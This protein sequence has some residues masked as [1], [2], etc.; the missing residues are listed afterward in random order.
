MVNVY[1]LKNLLSY[2]FDAVMIDVYYLLKVVRIYIKIK[3]QVSYNTVAQKEAVLTTEL[4]IMTNSNLI[5][6][7]QLRSVST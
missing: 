2:T 1:I 7:L 4:A 5:L 3:L 6:F